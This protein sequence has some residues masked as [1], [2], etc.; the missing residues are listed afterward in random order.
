MVY[1]LLDI[2][3]FDFSTG[4]VLLD[5]KAGLAS[6]SKHVEEVVNVKTQA[7]Q[8][9]TNVD[10]VLALLKEDVRTN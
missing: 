9:M 8:T 4:R 7:S 6:V 3:S 1:V 5:I 2:K 10:S